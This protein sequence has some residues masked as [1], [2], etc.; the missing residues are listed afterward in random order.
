MNNNS[1]S[2]CLVDDDFGDAKAVIRNF[3]KQ[4]SLIQIVR[5]TD[6]IDALKVMQG[7]DPERQLSRPFIAFIDINMPRM[8][9]LELIKKIRE[10]KGIENTVIFVLSTSNRQ[11]D[12]KEAYKNNISGYLVKGSTTDLY[13]KMVELAEIYQHIVTFPA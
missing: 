10:T 1:L 5:A 4:Q 12:I 7:E 2:I 3:N 8:N 6:G 9:G 11:E 13:P